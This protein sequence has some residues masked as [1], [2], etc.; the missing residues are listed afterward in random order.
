MG[1]VNAK[2]VAKAI[3]VDKFGFLGTSLGWALMKILNISTL[4]KIYD[5]NKHLKDV[6]F[7][8][9]YIFPGS[10][11]PCVTAIQKS[12]TQCT[13][14]KMA[15]MEDITPHY[16]RTLDAW[17]KRFL[18]NKSEIMAKGYGEDFIRQEPN[19]VYVEDIAYRSRGLGW[20]IAPHRHNRLS[21]VVVVFDNQWSVELL[22]YMSIA[23]C[24]HLPR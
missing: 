7:I 14:M 13:D 21:Q 12:F 15:H 5:R 4:N 18:A 1:L 9:R 24:Y 11:I 22:N 16:A 3:K 20:E 8:K 23:C 10:F 6:D 2:E 17:R 19:L